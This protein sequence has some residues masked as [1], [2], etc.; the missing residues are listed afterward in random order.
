MQEQIDE[1][2]QREETTKTMYEKIL[3]ALNNDDK[4]QVSFASRFM[5]A[6][7]ELRP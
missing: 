6:L 3:N 1:F 5:I 4:A 7:L 2:S